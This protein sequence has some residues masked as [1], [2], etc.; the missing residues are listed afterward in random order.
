LSSYNENSLNILTD[1]FL[2]T[3]KSLPNLL[4]KPEYQDLIKT[5]NLS[6]TLN[7]DDVLIFCEEYIKKSK[8]YSDLDDKINI[9][10]EVEVKRKKI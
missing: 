4:I 10:K 3:L 6:N 7:N 2:N 8:L 1:K 5:C 9:K